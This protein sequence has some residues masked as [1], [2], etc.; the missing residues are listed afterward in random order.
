MNRNLIEQIFAQ[1]RRA[2]N[3]PGLDE[4]TRAAGS[5]FLTEAERE[6]RKEAP[7]Q[8]ILATYFAA[9]REIAIGAA[10]SGLWAGVAAL[11]NHVVTHH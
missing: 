2:L 1:Y 7:D 6:F 10:G 4:A 3:G 9:M 5:D 8:S 11:L